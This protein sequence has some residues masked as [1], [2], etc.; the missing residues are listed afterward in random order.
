MGRQSSLL[1][2]IT[3]SPLAQLPTCREATLPSPLLALG[4][5]MAGSLAEEEKLMCLYTTRCQVA[6]GWMLRRATEMSPQ[7][8]GG[9][10]APS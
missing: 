7:L 6:L 1:P 2:S 5:L 3:S 4:G 8:L 9:L 10:T